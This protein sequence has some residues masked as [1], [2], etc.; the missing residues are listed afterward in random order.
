MGGSDPIMRTVLAMLVLGVVTVFG[1][2]LLS[3]LGAPVWIEVVALVAALLIAAIIGAY[4]L[5][6][7]PGRRRHGDRES[8]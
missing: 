4:G 6:S 5:I 8:E 2:L 1:L 7:T 3:V